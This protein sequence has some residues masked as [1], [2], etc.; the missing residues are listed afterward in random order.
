[1]LSLT[2]EGMLVEVDRNSSWGA[3]ALCTLD[4]TSWRQTKKILVVM[5]GKGENT[6]MKWNSTR[7]SVGNQWGRLP[8]RLY[9]PTCCLF[10]PFFGVFLWF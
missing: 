9:Q 5:V 3:I 10:F 4:D 2:N 6:A 7:T 8:Y 1:G